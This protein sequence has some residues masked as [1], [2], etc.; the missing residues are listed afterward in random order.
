MKEI[1]ILYLYPDMLELYGDYGNIQVLK[2]RIEARGYKA[3]ID[4]YSIGDDAPNFNDYDIVFA[5]GG[6][7]NEQSILADDLVK[8]KDNI[9]LNINLWGIRSNDKDTTKFNDV[10]LMF[11]QNKDTT[12]TIH[13]YKITTDP[14]NVNLQKPINKNGTAIVKEGQYKGLFKVGLHKGYE[15][16][17][18]A[19]PITV[20]RDNNKDDILDIKNNKE[21]TGMF[22]INMHRAS[23]N[24]NNN[25]IGLYSAGCQVHQDYKRFTYEFMPIIKSAI[26]KS[27]ITYTLINEDDL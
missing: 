9:N 22:G 11:Y 6:A 7:D 26:G 16:L 23:I 3:I 4:R 21:E 1:K 5:G 10:C 8:Y 24:G 15:A 27:S 14:S 2:Y 19:V 12:W 20:I 25:E 18:Q 13:T 17:V